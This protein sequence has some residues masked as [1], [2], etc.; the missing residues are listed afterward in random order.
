LQRWEDEGE[1]RKILLE[2]HL[3]GS[4]AR[5]SRET[6][7]QEKEGRKMLRVERYSDLL[8]CW[9]IVE[10][11]RQSSESKLT[12]YLVDLFSYVNMLKFSVL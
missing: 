9:N 7:I 12:C 11:D 5:S 8:S 3:R 2:K 6:R 10:N 4:L 1:R